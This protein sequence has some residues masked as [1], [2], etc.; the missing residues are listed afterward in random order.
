MK[1]AVHPIPH[2]GIKSSPHSVVAGLNRPG[3]WSPRAAWGSNARQSGNDRA[4][5][6]GEGGGIVLLAGAYGDGAVG[7]GVVGGKWRYVN[8]EEPAS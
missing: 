5:V 7:L 6:G 1:S 3:Y 4:G 8:A 2:A